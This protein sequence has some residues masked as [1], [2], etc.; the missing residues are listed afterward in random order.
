[1]VNKIEI[2]LEQVLAYSKL[3][4]KSGEDAGK[5]ILARNLDFMK[6]WT[7]DEISEI[8]DG[9]GYLKSTYRTKGSDTSNNPYVRSNLVKSTRFH[10]ITALRKIVKEKLQ[11][12]EFKMPSNVVFQYMAIDLV[13]EENIRHGFE[14]S[15]IVYNPHQTYRNLKLASRK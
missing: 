7:D 4:V 5:L 2:D 12:S 8:F 3:T 9:D 11:D 14:E 13:S 6:G 1:M 10:T 15:F